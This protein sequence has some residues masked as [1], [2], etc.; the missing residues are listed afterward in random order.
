MTTTIKCKICLDRDWDTVGTLKEAVCSLCY[1]WIKIAYHHPAGVKL[2]L[3]AMQ[4]WGFN[5]LVA[6]LTNSGSWMLHSILD[7]DRFSNAKLE[8]KQVLELV[9]FLFQG[10]P[11]ENIIRAREYAE[12]NV[13]QVEVD[14]EKSQYVMPNRM[15]FSLN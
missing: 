12:K 1:T 5:P 6:G 11:E 9:E 2:V 3:D 7:L 15:A 10:N 8:K 14:K 4:E 13:R